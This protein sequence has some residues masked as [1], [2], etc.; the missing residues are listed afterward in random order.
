M[1][2]AIKPFWFWFWWI[3]VLC[4]YVLH[5]A[6]LIVFI[7]C[8][9]AAGSECSS[10]GW[11][12]P[13]EVRHHRPDVWW[14]RRH[15]WRGVWMDCATSVLSGSRSSQSS[16]PGCSRDY[17][18]FR[19]TGQRTA[20][21]CELDRIQ[22]EC[23]QLPTAPRRQTDASWCC[24]NLGFSQASSLLC[25]QISYALYIV[26]CLFA[27]MKLFLWI[28]MF[29]ANVPFLNKFSHVLDGNNSVVHRITMT[30]IYNIIAYMNMKIHVYFYWGLHL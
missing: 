11:G 16:V 28:N 4:P 19:S 1:Y 20:D 30:W 26:V 3:D 24:R 14:G 12:G 8:F 27:L 13:L 9:T 29:L 22:A 23:R 7:D 15:Y 10:W 18:Q 6:V 5:R 17:R 2:L 25:G 21:V